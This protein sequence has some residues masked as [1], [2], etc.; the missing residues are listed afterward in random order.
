MLTHEARKSVGLSWFGGHCGSPATALRSKSQG[1]WNVWL[2]LS[3]LT[4]LMHSYI[5]M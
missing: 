1:N 4:L 2:L 5:L 3:T